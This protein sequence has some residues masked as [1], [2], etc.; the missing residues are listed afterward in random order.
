MSDERRSRGPVTIQTDAVMARVGE[1]TSAH[2]AEA[3]RRQRDELTREWEQ[4]QRDEDE[5]QRKVRQDAVKHWT[6]LVGFALATLGAMGA[7]VSWYTERIKAETREEVRRQAV[8]SQV[9]A[10]ERKLRSCTGEQ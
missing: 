9:E 4:R 3:L 5:R 6:G 8:D 10:L 7:F 1:Q 2:I